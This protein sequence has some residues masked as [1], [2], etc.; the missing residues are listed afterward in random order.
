M[1]FNELLKEEA[2]IAKQKE[3]LQSGE[4]EQE[5]EGI[6]KLNN[7]KEE[8]IKEIEAETKLVEEKIACEL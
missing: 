4:K 5:L 1:T 8:K 2:A 7:L 6:K 3:E